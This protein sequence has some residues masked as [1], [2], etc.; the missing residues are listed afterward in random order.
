MSILLVVPFLA[1]G[2]AATL[3]AAARAP[4]GYEDD[5]GFHFEAYRK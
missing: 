2:T 5:A 3:I 4:R 1:L